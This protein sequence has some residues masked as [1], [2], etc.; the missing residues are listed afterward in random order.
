MA[1]SRKMYRYSNL[2]SAIVPLEIYQV[3]LIQST[4]LMI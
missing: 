2:S 1:Y 4:A 3:M